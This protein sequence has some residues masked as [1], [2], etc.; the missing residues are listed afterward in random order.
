MPT[1]LL[2]MPWN[3]R[4]GI[5]TRFFFEKKYFQIN[6]E[7]RYYMIPSITI[8]WSF[9]Y[10]CPRFLFICD[11]PSTQLYFD[12]YYTDQWELTSLE[13]MTIIVR[14]LD[15]HLYHFKTSWTLSANFW[16][17]IYFCIH[18]REISDNNSIL[19]HHRYSTSIS[20]KAIQR[21]ILGRKIGW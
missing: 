17:I 12:R 15:L 11:V 14:K 21:S 5:S 8:H 19:T 7:T 1:D 3:E 20:A 2:R 18:D 10:L 9:T 16:W 13:I 6:W 4:S